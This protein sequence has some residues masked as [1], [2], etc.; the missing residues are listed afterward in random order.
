MKR[1]LFYLIVATATLYIAILYGSASFLMLFYVE[2]ALPVVLL[3]LSIPLARG[4]GVEIQLPI[5]LA[6]SGQTVP[7]VIW[8]KNPTPFPCGKIAVQLTSYYPMKKKGKKTWFYGS[9][10]GRGKAVSGRTRLCTE[11]DAECVGSIRMEITRVWC[12]DLIGLLAVPLSRRQW[13][14]LEPET[15]L[16][17]PAIR[18]VPVFVSR[19]SRDF[20]GESEE[21]SKERGGDDPSET[22]QIRDYKPGDKLRSIY[23]KLSA[24][25]EELMVCE[26]SLPLGCPVLFYLNLFQKPARGRWNLWNY[27]QS[28][29]RDRFLQ[30][31]ASLSHAMVQEGCRHYFIWYDT[32]NEDIQRYRVEKQEDV[33]EMLLQLGRLS[34][35]SKERNL[36][37]LYR[38]KY[39]E[40]QAVT[41]LEL[42]I[43][44]DL[45]HNEK[46]LI[47]YDKREEKLEQQLG[48]QEIIV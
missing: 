36:E 24:K 26:K 31:A 32:K 41:K 9:V 19:Q 25:T 28:T 29:K 2:L 30:I 15:L 46:K 3:V 38:Q 11:Y 43:D 33:Y 20:A 48:A 35:Y 39:H 6:E 16:V 22:F 42:T 5:P 23:W 4:V 37:E 40:T 10:P 14:Q 12:Y 1:L 21:Y 13:K 8:L 27:S 47:T 7:V 18:E 44:L 45:Y 17:V 34:T